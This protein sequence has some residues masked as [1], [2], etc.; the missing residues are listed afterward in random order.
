MD[1]NA[2]SRSVTNVSSTAIRSYLAYR[3]WRGPAVGLIVTQVWQG[4]ARRLFISFG[5]L[6]PSAYT[7]PSGVPERPHGQF[8]LT[9]MDSLSDWT[10]ALNGHVLAHNESLYRVRER[11][12]RLLTGR[13]LQSLRI[14]ETSRSTVLTFTHGLSLSTRTMRNTGESRPHWLLRVSREHWP[15]VVLRGTSACWRGTSGYY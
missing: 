14:D 13:R 4:Y 15:P 12:L 5:D 11:G 9:N 6:V 2:T 3:F 10:L 7:L 1:D 8:E